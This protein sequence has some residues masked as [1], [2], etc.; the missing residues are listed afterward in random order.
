M[1]DFEGRSARREFWWFQFYNTL[2]ALLLLA[3]ALESIRIGGTIQVVTGSVLQ[4]LGFATLLPSMA[5][6]IRR[7]HDVGKSGWWFLWG[8]VPYV[9]QLVLF[10]FYMR[11]GDPV[12]NAYGDPV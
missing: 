4:L 10:W 5:L 2:F 7:L 8:L 11:P 6:S 1:L 3:I 9:G 12:R